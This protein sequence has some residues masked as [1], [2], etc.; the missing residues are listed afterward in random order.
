MPTGKTPGRPWPAPPVSPGYSPDLRPFVL[1][2]G[3][4]SAAAGQAAIR[5]VSKKN[6]TTNL[7]FRRVKG[8]E[9]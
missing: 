6:G 8:N 4:P 1:R 2:G 5:D 3:Q 7:P 9:K